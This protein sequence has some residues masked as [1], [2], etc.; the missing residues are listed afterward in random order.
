MHTNPPP[1]V[2]K[3]VSESSIMSHPY[4]YARGNDQFKAPT[5]LLVLVLIATFFVL[6]YFIYLADEKRHG[7]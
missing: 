4:R 6:K 2:E 1:K 7:K 3:F 5:W